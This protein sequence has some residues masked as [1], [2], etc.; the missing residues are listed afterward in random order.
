MDKEPQEG[1]KKKRP[2]LK[3]RL[4]LTR[5]RLEIVHIVLLIL[6]PIVQSV[7]RVL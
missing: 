1:S 6:L 3:S 5:L 2:S 4:E 7:V